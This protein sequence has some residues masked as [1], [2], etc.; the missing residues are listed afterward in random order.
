M[1]NPDLCQRPRCR[2][3]WLYLVTGYP[4]FFPLGRVKRPWKVRLCREHAKGYGGQPRDQFYPEGVRE[5]SVGTL[6]RVRKER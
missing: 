4:H 2:E 3:R 5:D 6:T 1:K